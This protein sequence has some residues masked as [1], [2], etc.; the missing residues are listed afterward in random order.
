M[1]LLDGCTSWLG[2]G[3]KEPPGSWGLFGGGTRRRKDCLG[4]STQSLGP[5]NKVAFLID[6]LDKSSSI[7]IEGYLATSSH[8]VDAMEGFPILGGGGK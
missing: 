2:I 7:I 8:A 1:L 5:Q 4:G 3:G 6:G